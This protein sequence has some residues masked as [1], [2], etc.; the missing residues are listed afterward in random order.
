MLYKG[1]SCT[2][3]KE[4]DVRYVRNQYNVMFNGYLCSYGAILYVN[5]MK[6]DEVG[7]PLKD[8]KTIND[9]MKN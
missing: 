9:N 5:H 2:V 7:I 8:P 3:L 4:R 1:T 6:S